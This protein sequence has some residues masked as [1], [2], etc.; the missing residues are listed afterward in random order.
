MKLTL[1]LD[2]DIILTSLF[3]EAE[4]ISIHMREGVYK[5]IASRTTF[6]N[7]DLKSLADHIISSLEE[8]NKI[9]ERMITIADMCA[10]ID[11]QEDLTVTIEHPSA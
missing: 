10:S 2:K 1:K 5:N 9:Q 7:C 3:E 6:I 8:L 4:R 11:F